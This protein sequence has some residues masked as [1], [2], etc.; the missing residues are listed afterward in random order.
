MLVN[1]EINMNYDE[2]MLYKF[3]LAHV[4]SKVKQ[5][6]QIFSELNYIKSM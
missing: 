4:L 3:I 2:Y 1:A 6:N 5:T